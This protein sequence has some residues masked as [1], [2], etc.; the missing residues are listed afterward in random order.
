MSNTS[1]HALAPYVER[2]RKVLQHE[3]RTHHQDQAIKPGGLEIFVGR[4]ADEMSA[5]CKSAGLDLRPVYDFAECL[6]GYHKQDPMQRAASLRAALAILNEL[7]TP[8]NAQNGK[9]P[10]TSAQKSTTTIG[11][12][13]ETLPS[14]APTDKAPEVRQAITTRAEK[15]GDE[16][17]ITPT[18]NN[19]NTAS[20]K[21][22]QTDSRAEPAP[23]GIRLE[24]GMTTGHTVLTLL[25]ADITAVPKVG[26]A[27]ANRLRSLG[28]RTVR[29]LLF[30]FPRDHRDYSKLEKIANLPF[31]E[32]TT[33]K[34]LIWE[35]KSAPTK[36]GRSRTV[37]TISDET[38]KLNVTWFNQ[39]YLM[40]QLKNAQ[41]SWLVVTGT[42]QRFGNKIEFSVRSHELPEEGDLLNTGRLVPT[43]A[44]TEGLHANALRRYT[45]WVVD[46]YAAMVPDHLPAS[47]RLAGKLM[48]LPD[49]ISHIHYPEN[50]AALTAARRRLAFDELFLIQLGMQERRSR[51]QHEAP[52]G[53]AFKIDLGKI[54]IDAAQADE[55]AG[56]R[57]EAEELADT[58]NSFNATLWSPVLTSQPFEASLPFRFTAAQRRVISEILADLGQ[59]RPMCRLLQGDVG[60][61]KTAVAA[62]AL[63]TAALNGY[64]GAIMAPT[65]LLAE[66]HARSIS[67]MLEPF[68]IHTVLLTGSLK[69]RE[70]SLGRTAIE[71]GEAMV[72]I[73][74]HALIQEDVN[75]QRLGLVIVDEQHRFGVE[76]RDALRQKGY[77][78]HMLV[79]TATPIPRTLALTLYGDLDVSVIDQLPPGRQKTITRWRTGARRSEANTLIAHQVAEGR[80][81][82]IICP[83]IEESESLAVKAA[84]VEYERLSREVF[85]NLRLGLLHGAM[86]AAEKDATM[87]RFRDHELDILVATSVIEV[88]I[89]VP[90]ATVMVIEDADRF[91]LSQLHQ[92]RGRVGRGEHQSYCY[93][94][95]A[96][97]SIQAQERLEVFQSTD[98]GFRLSEE[99]MRLRG[100]GDFIGVRQSGM[101]E[102]RMADLNDTR[103][104]EESRS[105]AARLWTSDPYLRKPEHAPLRERMYL[106]WQNFMAH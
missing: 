38:G 41:G 72:A 49:A 61:G 56:T 21:P 20:K 52:N 35:V 3:Q 75:F 105:L 97:A 57:Q 22:I 89:D 78:P 81:A 31:N 6:Q 53:N 70:R 91:G 80:Q 59:S 19:N 67:V 2:A 62:A 16:H 77:H 58:P 69:Q 87:R 51:W 102:L 26:P 25:S 44:L 30:Y 7:D 100:P 18:G 29:D 99:D 9:A 54:F 86:K 98:D 27:A 43:Y 83:L 90:N 40:K 79:M 11:T 55:T 101:P 74:T 46:H 64:Q 24:A 13:R 42:K 15:A 37:A 4:W 92:F 68:G 84:T 33:T 47:I 17:T 8:G 85:P 95:S 104:I 96:D 23:Q 5:M 76:Q 63:L 50:E 106:F 71:N 39:P 93:V 28:I 73:G 45:K 12:K 32:V 1:Q 65:E 88:G 14:I 48:P 66:Q 36:G 60:A 34:G 94:L 82:F 10:V 103:L